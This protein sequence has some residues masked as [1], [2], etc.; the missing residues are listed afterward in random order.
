[1]TEGLWRL[2]LRGRA[3]LASLILQGLTLLALMSVFVLSLFSGDYA[4]A[5]LYVALAG[6]L[7]AL[8]E[9]QHAS[10]RI[11]PGIHSVPSD[12]VR[13]AQFGRMTNGASEWTF[14][15]GSGRWFRA[16]ALPAVEKNT[17]AK[18]P[19]RVILLDPRSE[20]ICSA[21]AEYRR[22]SLWYP[23]GDPTTSPRGIQAEILATIVRVVASDV[24]TRVEARIALSRTY[25]PVRVD[26]NQEWMMLTTP[27]RS[28]A[29]LLASKEHWL[30][31]VT[32]D[33]V[34][35]QIIVSPGIQWAGIQVGHDPWTPDTARSVLAAMTVIDP[36]DGLRSRLLEDYAL[37]NVDWDAVC[38]AVVELNTQ[39]LES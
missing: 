19:V 24:H 22:K 5:V 27:D 29:P 39:L 6:I 36:K 18:S 3:G 25:S 9:G 13:R 37:G 17:K 33:E 10:E 8:I 1:M 35:Q 20:A 26:A 30:Y 4:A 16:S 28:H 23:T 2:R 32:S 38:R 31:T 12:R 14:R 15:G 34:D 11:G 7:A 21:Y